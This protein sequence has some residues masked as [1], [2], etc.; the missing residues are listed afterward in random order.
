VFT[1]GG[2]SLF[3]SSIW[4][5]CPSIRHE[6]CGRSKQQKQHRA[7]WLQGIWI[8]TWKLGSNTQQRR[9]QE[10]HRGRGLLTMGKGM[11][12]R[13]GERNSSSKISN[14][15]KSFGRG[16]GKVKRSIIFRCV[17]KIAKKQLLASSCLSVLS[18]AWNNSALTGRI[19]MK[20]DIWVFFENLSWKIK[21]HYNLTRIPGTLHKNL[22]PFFIISSQFFL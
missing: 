5:K 18:S 21:F 13:W 9:C 15:G 22:H 20:F 8:I 17:R 14:T 10:L 1:P 7:S 11:G 16:C 6:S 4:W 19:F 3:P 2:K 12:G